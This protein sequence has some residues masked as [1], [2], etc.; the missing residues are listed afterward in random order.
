MEA[1]DEA[2]DV[3]GGQGVEGLLGPSKTWPFPLSR[4]EVTGRFGVEECRDP[5]SPLKGSLWLPC[6]AHGQ[7]SRDTQGERG[8][9]L[10][11]G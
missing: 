1:G 5:A 10:G 9:G 8:Q 2:R 11:S 4:M 6:W 7:K 3:T